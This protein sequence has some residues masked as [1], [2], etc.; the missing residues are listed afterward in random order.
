MAKCDYCGTVILFGG[1]K[2]H[3][4]RFC[5][6]TCHE[7]GRYLRDAMSIPKESVD[8]IVRDVHTKACPKC[9]GPGPVDVHTSYRVWSA[10][11]VTS[12][13]SE[14]E[15]CCSSCGIKS[16]LSNTAFC[17]LLGWW[18]IPWG[19]LITPVQVARNLIGMTSHPDPAKPSPEL[20]RLVRLHLVEAAYQ[21]LS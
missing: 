15:I 21:K 19:F 2:D 18:G 13:Y 10:I 11:V 16:K 5:N 17:L 8:E 14:P 7:Y 1:V 3:E 6:P 4:L 20:E 9:H 12:W